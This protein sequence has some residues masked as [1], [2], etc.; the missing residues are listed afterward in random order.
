MEDGVL[1]DD[2]IIKIR[3]WRNLANRENQKDYSED[4]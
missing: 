2:R 3:N 4:P 1:Q